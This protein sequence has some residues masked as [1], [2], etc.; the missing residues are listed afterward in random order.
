[1][2][3]HHCSCWKCCITSSVSLIQTDLQ[4]VWLQTTLETPRKPPA[5]FYHN[6]WVIILCYFDATYPHYTNRNWFYL[7][8]VIRIA[9]IQL[10]NWWVC[11]VK[12]LSEGDNSTLSF[13]WS[14][15]LYCLLSVFPS[16]HSKRAHVIFLLESH[17]IMLEIIVYK[18][19]YKL[20][21]NIRHYF[22]C[23]FDGWHLVSLW[24]EMEKAMMPLCYFSISLSPS[25]LSLCQSVSKRIERHFLFSNSELW[26][27]LALFRVY[28]CHWGAVR[29]V[30]LKWN[31]WNVP[32]PASFPST[33][34]CTGVHACICPLVF[35]SVH[36]DGDLLGYGPAFTSRPGHVHFVC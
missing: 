19:K 28:R 16:L 26:V 21:Y 32:V 11:K 35:A 30:P 36:F 4:C 22:H 14:A 9:F 29:W 25:S 13:V 15:L 10:L 6:F 18:A 31:G 33:R 3:P 1:M 23:S 7:L 8:F 2:R 20:L 27:S 5:L 12:L 24:L 34:T 17:W